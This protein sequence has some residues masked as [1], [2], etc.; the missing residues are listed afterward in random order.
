MTI[1]I[2]ET[3]FPPRAL[4]PGW[5][6]YASMVAGL[7][8]PDREYR[9]YT[10]RDGV[11]PPAVDACQAYVITGSS[12]GVYDDLPWIA[13]FMD[14]LRQARGRAKL[15]G[16]CFGHQALAEAFGGT[17]I[18][19]PMGWGLG[20][21][22][23]D[24]HDGFGDVTRLSWTAFHQDQVVRAPDGAE[25]LAS[26]AFTPFAALRYDTDAISIQPHPEFS[27]GFSKALIEAQRPIYGDR[28]APAIE[29][30]DRAPDNALAGD[31]MARF[32][33]QR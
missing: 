21:H 15:V 30:L 12:A 7:L 18:K 10:V 11:L 5:G 4:Q 25:V 22:D 33:G 13:P 14:F 8:G 16:I 20:L 9:T 3:G 17:V 31:W 27:P 28:A 2:L 32:I 23:Y 26:S 29:S 19:S 6:T 24:I 1:G